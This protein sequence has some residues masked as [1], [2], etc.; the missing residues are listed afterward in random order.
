MSDDR[1]EPEQWEPPLDLETAWS[2][3][4]LLKSMGWEFLPKEGGVL[5]QPEQL[6]QDVAK[7]EWLSSIIEPIVRDRATYA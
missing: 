7:V 3:W 1:E 6:M 2:V 4:T 5:D